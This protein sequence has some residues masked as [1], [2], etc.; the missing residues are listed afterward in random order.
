MRLNVRVYYLPVR[1]LCA[2]V[3]CSTVI[4]KQGFLLFEQKHDREGEGREQIALEKPKEGPKA[5]AHGDHQGLF[6]FVD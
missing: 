3:V 5:Y 6:R 4:G 1:L 2:H